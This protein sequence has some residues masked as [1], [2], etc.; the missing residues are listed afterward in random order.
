MTQQR[1]WQ[2]TLIYKDHKIQKKLEKIKKK[3]KT[4]INAN[5]LSQYR[6]H[7]IIN[8]KHKTKRYCS[9]NRDIVNP[10]E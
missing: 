7:W 4:D 2:T 5:F 3:K 9:T 10:H 8:Y 1:I 6:L